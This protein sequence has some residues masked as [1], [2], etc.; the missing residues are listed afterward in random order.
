[1]EIPERNVPSGKDPIYQDR[2]KYYLQICRHCRAVY[3]I[4][5]VGS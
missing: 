4:E 2:K 5:A 3:A 1:M